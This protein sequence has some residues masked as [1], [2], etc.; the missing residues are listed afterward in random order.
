[1]KNNTLFYEATYL[2]Y[3]LLNI[4]LYL[5]NGASYMH[6]A[7]YKETAIPYKDA[8]S[9]AFLILTE[10]A[11]FALLSSSVMK[12]NTPFQKQFY[13]KLRIAFGCF[14]PLIALR[15]VTLHLNSTA[16]TYVYMIVWGMLGI[17]SAFLYLTAFRRCSALV[18]HEPDTC[19][20]LLEEYALVLS[21]DE[22]AVMKKIKQSLLCLSGLFLLSAM[23]LEQFCSG[24]IIFTGFSIVYM[25]AVY[26]SLIAVFRYYAGKRAP[27]RSGLFALCSGL[28]CLAVWLVTQK[29]ISIPI[30]T[31]RTPEE[32]AILLLL[33]L[34][35]AL[36]WLN[37]KY[38]RYQRHRINDL[39]G[40]FMNKSKRK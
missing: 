35:P 28:G 2:L 24:G 10:I 13:R 30:L 20:Q 37:R 9:I 16:G 15:F 3:T 5:A 33:F 17:L 39:A 19:R 25:A 36:S 8:F 40:S 34:L 21:A 11:A 12:D 22:L 23:F 6:F 29:I 27:L 26:M 31:D 18:K 38:R 32:T 14:L 4:I 7:R 1:M